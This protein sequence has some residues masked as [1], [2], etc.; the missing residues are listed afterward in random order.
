MLLFFLKYN[1]QPAKVQYFFEIRKSFTTNLQLYV[2]YCI[3][4]VTLYQIVLSSL[5]GK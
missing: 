5:P 1:N 2:Y 3:F 4:A